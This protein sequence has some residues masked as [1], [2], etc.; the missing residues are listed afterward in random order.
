MI[1]PKHKNVVVTSYICET[2]SVFD[3]AVH[4][5]FILT[6]SEWLIKQGHYGIILY[7]VETPFTEAEHRRQSVRKTADKSDFS[8]KYN[9][10]AERL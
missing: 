10:A 5:H 4:K 3:Q 9:N 1:H 6:N 8:H 7:C 2:D